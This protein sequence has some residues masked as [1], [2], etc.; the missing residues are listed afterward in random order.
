MT[1]NLQIKRLLTGERKKASFTSES[2]LLPLLS[3]FLSFCL[4]PRFGIVDQT[5]GL[6]EGAAP[7][8][9]VL[10]HPNLCV[11]PNKIWMLNISFHDHLSFCGK[12]CVIISIIKIYIYSK[13]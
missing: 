1:H 4:N 12:Y 9:V 2:N 11:K 3:F 13:C 8:A 5:D 10:H 7:H 6:S